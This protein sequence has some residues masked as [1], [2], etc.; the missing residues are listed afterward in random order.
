MY[1]G[2]Q[3]DLSLTWSQIP[4]TGFSRD[5]FQ[6]YDLV[7]CIKYEISAILLRFHI[8]YNFLRL[9]QKNR[10]ST[11]LGCCLFL[12]GGSVV[13]DLFFLMLVPMFTSAFFVFGPCFE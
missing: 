13:V 12:S 10:T 9:S 7:K 3:A 5:F 6:I 4:K 8:S 11:C 1:V 2:E